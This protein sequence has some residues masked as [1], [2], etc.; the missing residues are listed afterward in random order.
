M[1][2]TIWIADAHR[3]DGK[4]YVVRDEKLTAF[5]E[6]ER[7]LRKV[8]NP[9]PAHDPILTTTHA[10]LATQKMKE[11]DAP[12]ASYFA[13]ICEGELTMISG[14]PRCKVIFPDTATVLPSY[15]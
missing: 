11:S 14:L 8:T 2:E 6:L 4:R 9:I 1:A 7:V 10:L 12:P 5:L 3:G 15:C 13:I